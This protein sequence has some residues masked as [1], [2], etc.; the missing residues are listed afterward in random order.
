MAYSLN[1]TAVPTSEAGLGYLTVWPT[2][3]DQPT[4]S[5]LND[6]TGTI[7]ANAAIVP[8][9]TGGAIAV[10]PN[11]ATN[12]VSDINGYFAPAGTGGMS[13]YPVAPCR[14]IDTRKGNGAFNGELNPPVDVQ[15]SACAPPSQSQAYVFN[16]TVVP[17]GP[18]GYLT[19]WP[20]GQQQPHGL[21]LERHRRRTSPPTWRWCPPATAKWMPIAPAPPTWCSISPAISPRRICSSRSRADRP[22]SAD[23]A[24]A[25]ITTI[26]S[27]SRTN[28]FEE[29]A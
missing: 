4:V 9:G 1:F 12:L 5:T 22:M 17:N 10:Y 21:N 28:A 6:P 25:S 26:A 13:F 19:L 3:Q 7:V 2:G 23:P 8:A 20:D 27:A 29:R 18:L 14:V 15:N 24:P 16:A 11:D